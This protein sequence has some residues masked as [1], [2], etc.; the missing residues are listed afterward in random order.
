MA[1]NHVQPGNTITLTAPS[2]GVS[3]GDGVLIGAFFGV[4][5]YDAEAGDEVEVDLTG[6]W[7][8]PKAAEAFTEGDVVYWDTTPGQV[9]SDDAGYFIGAVTRDA[10]SGDATAR[11]RLNGVAI[12]GPTSP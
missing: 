6:V 1:T 2:G 3:S 10:A 7:D 11:V 9:S 12:S 8:L 4:A 5:Q